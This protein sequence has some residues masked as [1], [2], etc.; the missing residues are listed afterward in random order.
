MRLTDEDI[1]R[2]TS[3]AD[4]EYR[5]RRDRKITLEELEQAALNC[6]IEKCPKC[7]WWTESHNLLDIDEEEVDGFCDNCRASHKEHS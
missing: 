6:N 3:L 2:L 4:G 5:V 7:G 1:D